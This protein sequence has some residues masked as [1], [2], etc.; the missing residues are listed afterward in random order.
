MLL[1]YFLKQRYL[2]GEETILNSETKIP[3]IYVIYAVEVF[4]KLIDPSL[5]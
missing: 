1:S 4:M 5:N 2:L 3:L